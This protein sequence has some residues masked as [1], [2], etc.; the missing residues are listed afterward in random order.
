MAY[1][2]RIEKD[3]TGIAFL[4]EL[5]T[6]VGASAYSINHDYFWGGADLEIWTGA[7][8]SGTR[9]TEGAGNDY[10]LGG[11]TTTRATAL[12][13][14]S[15]KTVYKTV[16]IVNVTYQTG[17]LYFN[18]EYIADDNRWDDVMYR[19]RHVNANDLSA[20]HTIVATDRYDLYRVTTG[21]S[22]KTITLPTAS[23]MDDQ[24]LKIRKEDSGTGCVK[25]DPDSAETINGISLI[26][27]FNQYDTIEIESNGTEW[28]IVNSFKPYFESGWINRS[29]WTNVHLGFLQINYGSLVGTFTVGEIITGGTS[30]T[31]AI[32][33]DDTASVLTVVSVTGGTNNFT[34]TETITGGTSGA[35]ATV[36]AGTKN[37]DS[38]VLHNWG[39]DLSDINYDFYLSE[40]AAS[41]TGTILDVVAGTIAASSAG[42]T[43]AIGMQQSDTNTLNIAIHT[44]G[45]VWPTK[46][47]SIVLVAA[48]DWYYNILIRMS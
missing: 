32:I 43:T 33:I 28:F 9:L 48:Q 40:N 44:S 4:D 10:T 34:N 24:V 5:H 13:T 46:T 29:D 36:S 7:G 47:N 42:T 17:N 8:K 11:D 16:T 12:T 18:G 41:G 1:I 45:F 26:F 25:I 23:S 6:N 22:L 38:N 31:T 39:I 2:D 15:G 14:E 20:D 35:T 3:I 37:V 21:S 27:L 19:H 30:A